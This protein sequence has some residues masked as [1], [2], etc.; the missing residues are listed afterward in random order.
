LL[1]QRAMRLA[2]ALGVLIA[3]TVAADAAGGHHPRA[4]Q[5]TPARSQHVVASERGAAAGRPSFA[6]PGWTEEETIRW[7]DRLT[8]YP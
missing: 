1:E 5:T 7:M 8:Q 6:V 2:L 4:R 3:L